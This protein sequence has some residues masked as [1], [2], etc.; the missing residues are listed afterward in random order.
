M[1]KGEYEVKRI[2]IL[3]A[4]VAMLPPA[5]LFATPAT[6]QPSA[7]VLNADRAHGLLITN[8]VPDSPAL[9]AGVV[10]GDILIELDGKK[11]STPDQVRAVLSTHSAG[12]TI[13]AVIIHGSSLERLPIKL[14]VRLYHPIL[15]MDFSGDHVRPKDSSVPQGAFVDSVTPGGPADR[16]GIRRG[17]II[18]SVD[19]TRI[20]PGNSLADII[21]GYSAGRQISIRIEQPN[22]E[23]LT[24]SIQ[25]GKASNGGPLLGLRYSRVPAHQSGFGGFLKNLSP[26]KWFRYFGEP[27]FPNQTKAPQSK[28]SSNN[29]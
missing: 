1:R 7:A 9:R 3:L 27:L 15:G 14:E 29:T 24:L 16:A 25:L 17:D 10:R 2:L 18:L 22:R 20:G 23:K 13:T 26:P 6:T 12:D 19:G 4:I 21:R 5:V 28:G 11:V 8:V